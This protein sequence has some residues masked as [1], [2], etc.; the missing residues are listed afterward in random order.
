MDIEFPDEVGSKVATKRTSAG[1]DADQ[2]PSNRGQR[3]GKMEKPKE[4]P[5]HKQKEALSVVCNTSAS[6]PD[7]GE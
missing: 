6:V 1:R 7:W 2:G 4:R 3:T 5:L